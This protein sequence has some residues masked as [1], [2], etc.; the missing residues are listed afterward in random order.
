MT[1]ALLVAL[2]ASSWA[3]VGLVGGIE[4]W[5]RY[6]GLG[7]LLLIVPALLRTAGLPAAVAWVLDLVLGGVLFSV[8]YGSEVVAVGTAVG[9]GPTPVGGGPFDEFLARTVAAIARE[10]VPA[11]PLT[12]LLIVLAA[13]GIIVGLLLDLVSWTAPVLAGVVL[14]AVVALPAFLLPGG[15]DLAALAACL[16][17]YLL[18]LAASAGGRGAVDGRLGRSGARRGAR[19]ATAA[20]I[21]GGSVVLAL[22]V[23]ALSP[24]LAREW[25][26]TFDTT[27]GPRP[28]A[29]LVDLARDLERASDAEVIRY[30]TERRPAPY[31]QL[32]TLEDFDGTTWVHRPGARR[33]LPESVRN[34]PGIPGLWNDAVET[35]RIES[36]VETK[37]LDAEWAPAPYPVQSIAGG[38]ESW[39]IDDSD[40]AVVLGDSGLGDRSYTV[41]TRRASPTEAE[42]A[43]TQDLFVD[44]RTGEIFPIEGPGRIEATSAAS[45]EAFA[46]IALAEVADDLTL[47]DVLPQIITDTAIEITR[48]EPT[49]IGKARA[50][51]EYLRSRGGFHYSLDTPDE[52]AVDG[53]QVIASFLE[54]KS[55]YCVHFASAMTVL[56]RSVG[57]PARIAIGYL[58]GE[59]ETSPEG[60][61]YYSISN[62]QLHSWPQLY[63]AGIGWL[64]FEPTAGLGTPQPYTREPTAVSP[65]TTPSPSAAPSRTPS[66]PAREIDPLDEAPVAEPIAPVVTG[67]VVLWLLVALGALAVLAAPGVIRRL[68][69]RRRLQTVA[70]GKGAVAAWLE[71]RDTARDLGM[72]MNPAETPRAFATRL[73]YGWEAEP[74]EALE[75]L[76]LAAEDAAFGTGADAGA[77]AP[78]ALEDATRTVLG[79]MESAATGGARAVARLLPRSLIRERR[80]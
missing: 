68:R 19:R 22:A 16:L 54:R 29:S 64:D 51:Q 18:V 41:T 43:T 21:I 28:A 78:E 69:R 60:E 37:G 4:W 35:E 58:P 61:E 3:L 11:T 76:L 20:A 73:S 66:A 79:R 34:A 33:A 48:D 24:G 55:G 10:V 14:L 8:N 71:V 56:A 23:T 45:I 17:A 59:R 42:L 5:Q 39:A 9:A 77:S 31:L 12:E 65:S 70:T 80:A 47:P 53:M 63:F 62:Q 57:I 40:F 7:T 50:I 46:Q 38:G 2:L 44:L 32:A 13:F 75:S 6:V 36:T 26:R 74:R 67:R 15:I 72:A 25:W 52:T 1:G 49:A 30:T 27:G